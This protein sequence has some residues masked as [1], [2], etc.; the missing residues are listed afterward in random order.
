M[1]EPTL[2]TLRIMARFEKALNRYVDLQ[3]GTCG[4]DE[5]EDKAHASRMRMMD[6]LQGELDSW[7]VKGGGR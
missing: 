5:L 4:H 7:V 1:N 2:E 3:V 6:M